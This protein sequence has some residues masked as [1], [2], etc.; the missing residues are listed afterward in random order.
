MQPIL[1][2]Q[3]LSKSFKIRDKYF[4]RKKFQV[5]DNISFCLSK[6][7][8][9]AIIGETGSGKSTLAKILAGAE[10][11]QKGQ[12]LLEGKIIE[13]DGKRKTS[14][15]D[16][17][18]IFQD[19]SKS[20]N[21]GITIGKTLKEI[22][23]MNTD[24]DDF[25]CKETID[26]ILLKVGLLAE[27]QHY[28]PHM[29]S[30]GQLQRVALA[31]ALILEPKVLVLDEALSS[32]DP[33]VRAQTVNLLLKLQQETGLSYVLITHHLSLVKHMSDQTLVLDQGKVIESGKT[34]ALFKQHKSKITQRLLNC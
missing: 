25:Q 11:S 16:I 3:A 29:F 2:V 24:F 7:E 27:H 34:Q 17:R 32:L 26:K 30:G 19:A 22:L 21:P 10:T 28:Y 23:L 12:I 6:G 14:C 4:L 18:L 33:S 1:K 9:I 5:L 15:R 31:R 20:L 13:D 8:T